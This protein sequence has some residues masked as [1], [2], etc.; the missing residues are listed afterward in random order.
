MLGGLLGGVVDPVV[1]VGV[2]DPVPAGGF[3]GEPV[4]GAPVLEGAGSAWER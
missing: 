3:V 4:V 2:L 1:P